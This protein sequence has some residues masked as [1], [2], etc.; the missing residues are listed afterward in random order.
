MG[1]F[2][3]QS[4]VNVSKDRIKEHF[5]KRFSGRL[6]GVGELGEI[7]TW[8]CANKL[9][10]NI[11]KT[12]FVIFHPYQKKLNYSMKI[13]IDGK[14]INAHKSVKYLG[15]LIDCQLNWKEHIQQL[16]KKNI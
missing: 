12:H 11:D 3:V 5:I 8:L 6:V 2:V 16:S 4:N 9:S 15:I 1:V 13:E 14:T 7:N 10:L